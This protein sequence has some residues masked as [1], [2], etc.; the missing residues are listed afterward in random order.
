MDAFS[1]LDRTLRFQLAEP[2]TAETA[3]AEIYASAI[4]SM[5]NALVVV[6]SMLEN[7]SRIYAGK[8]ARILGLSDYSSENS[9]WETRILDLMPESEREQK[10]MAELRFFDYLRRLPIA[11]RRDY[12]LATRLMME[13]PGKDPVDV[14]HRMYYLYTADCQTITQAVCVYQP[15]SSGMSAR[16][17]IVNSVTGVREP[18]LT[19]QPISLLSRRELQVLALIKDGCTSAEIAEKLYISRNTVSRH[20]QSI[21]SALQVRNTTEAVSVA[22]SLGLF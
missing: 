8:F 19:C 9:I 3:V 10:Y 1:K 21:I 6:S 11:F 12:Y 7:R 20:R 2:E 14:L 15:L 13:P 16:S 22:T 5:E 17:E 4:A 18:L